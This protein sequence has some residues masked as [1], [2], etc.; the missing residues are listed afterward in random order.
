MGFEGIRA[1]DILPLLL[2]TFYPE[3]FLGFAN[4]IGPFVDRGYR[5]NFDPNVTED[6]EFI[7]QV[8]QLDELTIDL[9]IVKP[10][11]MIASFRT[12]QVP[13]TFFRRRSAH[14]CVRDP[15]VHE[16]SAPKAK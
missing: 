13:Q 11:Q 3:R 5:H 4:I 7:D 9:G 2:K 16:I 1:Q 6:S 12:Q 8:A 15:A 10:T 14:F